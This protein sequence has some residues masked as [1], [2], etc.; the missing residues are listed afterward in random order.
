MTNAN[1]QHSSVKHFKHLLFC[2]FKTY[3]INNILIF[4]STVYLF[5]KLQREHVTHIIMQ[6]LNNNYARKKY[7]M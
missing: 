3:R 6:Y 5:V 4:K 2:L 7:S 1:I